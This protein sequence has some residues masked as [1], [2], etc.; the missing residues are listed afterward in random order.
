MQ[1]RLRLISA[2]IALQTSFCWFLVAGD[3]VSPQLE[4]LP[5]SIEG[6][7]DH[8]EYQD[9]LPIRPVNPQA[10]PRDILV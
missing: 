4:V 5:I 2:A 6:L 9:A 10:P 3:L 8:V 1:D 7:R